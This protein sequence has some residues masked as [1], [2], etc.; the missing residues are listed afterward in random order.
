MKRLLRELADEGLIE[1]SRRSLKRP[2]ALPPVCVIEVVELDSGG[3]PIAEPARRDPEDSS[4]PRI[5]LLPSTRRG[6]AAPGVGDRVLARLDELPEPDE[7]GCRYQARA[8][9]LLPRDQVRLLGVYRALE[10]GGGVIDPVD[11]RQLREW[12]V[13]RG[14]AGEARSGELVRFALAREHRYGI[15]QARVIE[16]LGD[17]GEHGA[18]SLIAIQVHGLRDDFPEA[19]RREAEACEPAGPAG[20]EDLRGLPLVTIDPQGARD[21]DDAVWAAPSTAPGNEGG[22]SVIVAIADVA[23]Y[24]RAG[25]A[26]DREALTRGNSVYFPDRVVPM[27]PEVLSSGLCSLVEGE[28]RAV[29][30][31]AME[32]DKKG[33]KRSHRFFRALMRSAA[34][35]IYEQVQAAHDAPSASDIAPLIEPVVAPLFGAYRALARARDE[36]EPL[37]LDLPER[38]IALD[39]QGRVLGVSVPPRLD[40]HRLIEEF[41]IQANVAA[42]EAL[43]AKSVPLIY[44]VHDKPSAEKLRA[45]NEFL[46]SLDLKIPL[47][48][49]LRPHHFNRALEA[50]RSRDL[51]GVVGEVVLRSQAQAEYSPANYGHFGLNLRRYAH[52]TSPIRRYADLT[53]HRSLIRAYGFGAGGLSDEETGRLEAIAESI[54]LSERRA[55]AAERETAERLIAEFLSERVGARFEAVVSGAVKSGLF[56]RLEETGAEGFIPASTI[57]AEFF[58]HDETHHALYGE[59]SGRE[60]A[61][62]DRVE[63]RLVE[64]IPTA[65]ALRFEMLSEGT[66]RR[67]ARRPARGRPA[68]AKRR[69]R[70]ARGRGR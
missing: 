22:W 57:G 33:V 70:R 60:Y 50:A 61:L 1:G 56:V 43:E 30:A 2:D 44:R 45:L 42:A 65:G 21:H 11:K 47:S 24:V 23:H 15:A 54:S 64:A 16:R 3:E 53:V 20:R 13:R 29:L 69:R 26:L 32:F 4:P 46:A 10:G 28:D 27:L 18:Q 66:L 67:R 68:A 9:K 17:P 25:S 49:G 5:R 36:R 6:E 12:L 63:V 7:A 40:A 51:E 19:A 31:V 35:L 34:T 38:K 59:T 62:G 41:M 39:E 52:F 58:S 8:I 48:G 55:M 37:D 14:D